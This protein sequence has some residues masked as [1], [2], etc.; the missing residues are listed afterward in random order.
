MSLSFY[1]SYSYIRCFLRGTWSSSPA[2]L[3]L[4]AH[5]YIY[6]YTYMHLDMVTMKTLRVTMYSIISEAQD[7]VLLH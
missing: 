6:I 5:M 2:V 7:S 1:I 4:C 3:A